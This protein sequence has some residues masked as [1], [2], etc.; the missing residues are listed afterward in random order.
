MRDDDATGLEVADI[1]HRK[2]RQFLQRFRPF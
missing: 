2:G 1:F